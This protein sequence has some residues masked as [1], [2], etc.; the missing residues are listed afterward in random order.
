VTESLD[1]ICELASYEVTE[2]LDV[3]CKVTSLN[4]Q[5]KMRTPQT[6]RLIRGHLCVSKTGQIRMNQ[7]TC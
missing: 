2:L 7:R 4:T 5:T 1:V 6:R 3:L